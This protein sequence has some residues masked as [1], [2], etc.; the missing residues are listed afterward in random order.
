MKSKSSISYRISRRFLDLIGSLVGVGIFLVLY[1]VL[2]LAIKLESKGPVLVRLE[3]VSSGRV[4][5]LYKFRSMTDGA[6][7]LKP[8]LQHL[9]ER[10]DGP[11]FKIKDDPRLTK[12]GKVIRRFRLDEVPQFLN[13]LIGDLALVGPRPHEPEEVIKYPEEFK[14]LALE[15][16]GITGLSQISGAS[17][18]PFLEELTL[19]VKYAREKNIFL[20]V[21]IIG[22]TILIMIS[23]PSAV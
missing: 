15:K 1:P 19:D 8:S 2:G 3:R 18:L 13:V 4:I 12:V 10:S 9:N 20:D 7:K 17:G 22:K 5:N 21:R 14:F 16:S 11:F 23:D 6:H